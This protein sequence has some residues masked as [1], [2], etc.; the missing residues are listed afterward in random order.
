MSIPLLLLQIPQRHTPAPR[1]EPRARGA[2]WVGDSAAGGADVYG[3]A[4]VLFRGGFLIWKGVGVAQRSEGD[5]ANG[6][7]LSGTEIC[8]CAMSGTELGSYQRYHAM[9]GTEMKDGA[10]R[11][12]MVNRESA[13]MME[14]GGGGA[15]RA[16]L[17]AYA[18]ADSVCERL[19]IVL[20]VSYA[21]SGTGIANARV[22]VPFHVYARQGTVL[23]W[24]MLGV[25]WCAVRLLYCVL[26]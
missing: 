25:H 20:R 4:R 9:S 15:G 23:G 24:C 1:P 7:A 18:F 2:S 3:R 12:E 8:F 14:G 26:Y 13:M 22:A 10:P 19:R 6:C 16:P 21:V 5:V 17:P 11:W